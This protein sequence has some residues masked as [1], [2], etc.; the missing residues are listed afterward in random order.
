MENWRNKILYTQLQRQKQQYM[1]MNTGGP[2]QARHMYDQPQSLNNYYG[3]S[4]EDGQ[5][6]VQKAKGKA[7]A[8]GKSKGK[9]RGKGENGGKS[10]RKKSIIHLLSEV[11]GGNQESL[12]LARESQGSE[13]ASSGGDRETDKEL[14]KL[15][16]GNQRLLRRILRQLR[17][18]CVSVL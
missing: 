3:S 18:R 17:R 11:L 8:K 1:L 16:E 10:S 6:R 4:T 13:S 15:E 7:K 2:P 14:V 5:R 12:A 9:G